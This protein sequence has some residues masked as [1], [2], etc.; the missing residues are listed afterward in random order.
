MIKNYTLRFWMVL[1][2]IH[3]SII[4]SNAQALKPM[5]KLTHA[6]TLRGTYGP[7]RDWWDVLKYDLHVKFKPFAFVR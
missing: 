1:S 4:H 5:Q 3:Y 7:S 2:I 6:D